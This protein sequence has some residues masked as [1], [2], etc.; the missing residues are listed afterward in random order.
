MKTSIRAAKYKIHGRVFPFLLISSVPL[1]LLW[2]GLLIN[3]PHLSA[4]SNCVP[5]SRNGTV[6]SIKQRKRN[7]SFGNVAK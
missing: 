5:P 7:V 3:L 4:R 2:N 1:Q 6:R